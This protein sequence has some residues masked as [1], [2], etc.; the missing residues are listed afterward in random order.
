MLHGEHG[1][2]P[3]GWT[4]DERVGLLV[5]VHGHGAVGRASALGLRVGRPRIWAALAVGARARAVSRPPPRV[6]R[7]E[8]LASA[9]ACETSLKPSCL[10][11]KPACPGSP[12]M[13]FS[14]RERYRE[15]LPAPRS[16]ETLMNPPLLPPRCRPDRSRRSPFDLRLQG[17]QAASAKDVLEV[18]DSPPHPATLALPPV[19]GVRV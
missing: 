8:G 9:S 10:R 18:L 1:S 15:A 17:G 3:T 7:D 2:R 14:Y 6:Q 13:C 11:G 12:S 4:G 16:S 19:L 5:D